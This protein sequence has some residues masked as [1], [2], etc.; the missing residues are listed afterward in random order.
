M[1]DLFYAL[2]DIY[3]YDS[4]IDWEAL[5]SLDKEKELIEASTKLEQYIESRLQ[6]LIPENHMDECVIMIIEQLS[7][8]VDKN[9]FIENIALF[10]LEI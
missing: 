2:S 4:K 8:A 7:A 5:A 1:N 10:L 6:N 9:S 3:S